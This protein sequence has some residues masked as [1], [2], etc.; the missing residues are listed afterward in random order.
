MSDIRAPYCQHPECHSSRTGWY[1]DSIT[2]GTVWVP[3]YRDGT[4]MYFDDPGHEGVRRWC[5]AHALINE[6][7]AFG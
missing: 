4:I 5:K 2:T 1:D 7:V 3:P 6:G